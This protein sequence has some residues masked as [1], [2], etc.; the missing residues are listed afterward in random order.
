VRDGEPHIMLANSRFHPY[1]QPCRVT[2]GA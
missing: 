1:V 2:T